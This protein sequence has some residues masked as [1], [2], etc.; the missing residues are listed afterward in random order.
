LST[1]DEKKFHKLHF[2]ILLGRFTFIYI[3]EFTKKRS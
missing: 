1:E 2:P 3:N